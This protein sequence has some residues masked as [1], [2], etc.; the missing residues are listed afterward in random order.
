MTTKKKRQ[1]VKKKTT[2]GRKKKVPSKKA[3]SRKTTASKKPAA[4]KETL[5][6]VLECDQATLDNFKE[7]L[8]RYHRVPGQ[9]N[10][11]PDEVALL[12]FQQ[13]LGDM[14][15]T[16]DDLKDADGES[17]ASGNLVDIDDSD[18]EDDPEFDEA[19]QDYLG[20]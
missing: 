2:G 4:K 17:K 6:V 16:T 1:P 18:E 20:V 5:R 14:L 8:D 10:A 12:L 3:A 7:V 9:E 13:A 19:F 15:V 11:T